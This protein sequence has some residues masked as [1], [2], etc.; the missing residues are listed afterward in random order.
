MAE[1][2]TRVFVFI[3]ENFFRD[4]YLKLLLQKIIQFGLV[5][6]DQQFLDRAVETGHYSVSGLMY[7]RV[8]YQEM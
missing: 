6:R 7:V 5:I 8:L 1:N 3:P 2:K 4:R